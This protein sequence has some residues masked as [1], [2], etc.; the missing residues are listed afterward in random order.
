MTSVLLPDL[1]ATCATALETLRG[2]HGAAKDSVTALVSKDG[3][4]DAALF[5]ANQEAAH[6]YAWLT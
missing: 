5:E 6:G 1:L 2:L 3:K 4:I